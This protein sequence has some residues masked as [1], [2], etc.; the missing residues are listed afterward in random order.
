MWERREADP[1]RGAGIGLALWMSCIAAGRGDRLSEFE[2][3][4]PEPDLT[5]GDEYNL[6]IAAAMHAWFLGLQVSRWRPW[7]RC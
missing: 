5:G 2:H 4:L 1:D 6:M 3:L 7:G